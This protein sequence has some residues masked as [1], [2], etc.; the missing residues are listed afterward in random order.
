MYQ[1]SSP[2][3]I[4]SRSDSH[5][6]TQI[7]SGSPVVSVSSARSASAVSMQSFELVT[8]AHG[9]GGDVISQFGFFVYYNA[10]VHVFYN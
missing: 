6:S 9:V 10:Y 7:G 1:Q 5:R 8:V 2:A 3:S 4:I